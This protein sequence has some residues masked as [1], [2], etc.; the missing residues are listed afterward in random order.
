MPDS[1]RQLNRLQRI[2][3][4]QTAIVQSKL[5]LAGFMQL[6]VNT[7]QELTEA[8]G[9]VIELVEGEWMVYRCGSGLMTEH[10]GLRLHRDLH[11][12]I[13]IWSMAIFMIVSFTGVYLGF[14][15]QTSAAINAVFPGRD[16][17][18]AMFQA[19]VAPLPDT[20]P[21]ALDAAIALAQERVPEG[22]F[23]NAFLPARPDQALRIGMIRAGHESGA[24]AITVLVDPWR[25]SVIDVFDP[26]SFSFG[27]SMIAWQ[28]ALHEGLGLG[29]VYRFLVFLSGIIIPVFAVTGFFMWWIKR[30]NRR[31]TERAKQAAIR[32]AAEGRPAE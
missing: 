14:P 24:P 3:D 22:R 12:M 30:R 27:E 7:L 1:H 6:T 19:M 4:T 17:R 23:L 20:V 15:Q 21:I 9:A 8:R 11:G 2:I 32:Q 18:A 31:N 28:R 10:V 25:H 13:G 5:D 16:M 26:R 29:P